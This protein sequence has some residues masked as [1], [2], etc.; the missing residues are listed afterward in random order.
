M[1]TEKRLAGNIIKM[2]GDRK[3]F[4]KVL[5]GLMTSRPDELDPDVKS[6]APIQIPIFDL[7]GDDRK[8]F[9]QALFKRKGIEVPDSELAEVLEITASYSNRDYDF[10]VKEVK[11]SGSTSVVET[12]KV[13]QASSSI[14]QQRRLQS[15]IAAQHCSYPLL[16]PADLKA[17][18]E[19]NELEGEIHTLKMMLHG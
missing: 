1:K 19:G 15:M 2:M 16:L 3:L 12:L 18:A 5:W 6:R 10:L 9:V 11:G 7:E 13:W 14:R 17:K 8:A 4:G